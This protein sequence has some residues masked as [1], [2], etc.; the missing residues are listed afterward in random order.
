[1][2]LRLLA[3][4]FLVCAAAAAPC[5]AMDLFH[6]DWQYPRQLPPAFRNHCSVD[7]F[8]GRAYCSDRCGADYQ[9]YYCAPDSYACCHIGHGY[10]DWNGFV[11]CHP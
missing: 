3:L 1:M 8:S 4:C 6:G 2:M 9:F 11:R 7:R 10:C 5:Q